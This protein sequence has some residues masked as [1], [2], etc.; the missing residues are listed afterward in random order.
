MLTRFTTT[1]R[2]SFLLVRVDSVH[3]IRVAVTKGGTVVLK[4]RKS[5]S[6]KSTGTVAEWKYQKT[7]GRS[8]F[9]VSL[10]RFVRPRFQRRFVVTASNDSDGDMLDYSLIISPVMRCDAGIYSCLISD[11]LFEYRCFVHLDVTGLSRL[12]R[13]GIA[14]GEGVEPPVLSGH[15]YKRSFLSENRF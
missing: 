13:V 6:E 5:G 4:C 9:K 12:M 8:A 10:N 15:V 14:A 3:R 11:E 7:D 1:P 2:H